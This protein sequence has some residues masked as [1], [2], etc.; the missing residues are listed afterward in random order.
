MSIVTKLL[1]ESR[2]HLVWR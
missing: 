1:D 2:C